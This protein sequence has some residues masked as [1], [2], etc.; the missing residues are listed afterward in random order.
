MHV[1]EE[2][3]VPVITT[4]PCRVP[5][6]LSPDRACFTFLIRRTGQARKAAVMHNRSLGVGVATPF[7]QPSNHQTAFNHGFRRVSA[8]NA[9][10]CNARKK[11]S[12]CG[13]W[14][15]VG[16]PCSLCGG[17]VK[18][19]VATPR[20]RTP[21]KT[22]ATAA[23]A[24]A[25]RSLNTGGV[26][27]SKG[28]APSTDF[29]T[30]MQRALA[31]ETQLAAVRTGQP[32]QQLQQRSRTPPAT[33]G[34][35]ARGAVAAAQP[36][37][38]GLGRVTQLSLEAFHEQ[39]QLQERQ[40][41]AA[42]VARSRSPWYA[43][44]DQRSTAPAAAHAMPRAAASARSTTPTTTTTTAAR[45]SVHQH[46]QPQ[47]Q[48]HDVDLCAVAQ[49]APLTSYQQL[50]AL[51]QS[52]S[53]SAATSN[54]APESD[55]FLAGRYGVSRSASA[56][57]GAITATESNRRSVSLQHVGAAAAA[58]VACRWCGSNTV[59]G[60]ACDVCRGGGR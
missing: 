56:Q 16:I 54:G 44:A 9:A 45:H 38:G 6:S 21:V 42:A 58:V 59:S 10:E 35:V 43:R 50:V 37:G 1:A 48:Q 7:A 4:R 23:A 13:V 20:S 31:A 46:H 40:A 47:Q 55:A 28:G 17:L 32:Q 52:R 49:S 18:G 36:V 22:S 15:R 11:C 51:C 60:H 24:L 27:M 29:D 39:Q 8:Y 26:P 41:A 33:T 19:Q 34:A 57:S 5:R 12:S 3:N 25:Q 30:W 53:A 14:A 2:A